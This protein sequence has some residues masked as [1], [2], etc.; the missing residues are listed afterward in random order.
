MNKSNDFLEMTFRSIN[1]FANDGKLDVDELNEIVEIALKDGV[2]DANE[3]RVLASII[4][5]L[6][7][8]ELVGELA[9]KVSQIRT[10]YGF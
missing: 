7:A 5:K 10:E 3:K 4:S 2:V 1:C 8:E 9:D 6:N